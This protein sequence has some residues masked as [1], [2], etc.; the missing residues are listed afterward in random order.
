MHVIELNNETD[1][2]STRLY[3]AFYRDMY[4]DNS[5]NTSSTNT[6]KDW[7]WWY[8]KLVKQRYG[9]FM[10]LFHAR[11]NSK[12]FNRDGTYRIPTSE[13]Q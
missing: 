12:H 6:M 13:K 11:F 2:R 5:N 1:T 8:R 3:K 7:F 10:C 9:V 4:S